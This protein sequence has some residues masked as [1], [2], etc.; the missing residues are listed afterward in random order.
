[1]TPSKP[2]L[3]VALALGACVPSA[4]T[5]P[6][7]VAVVVVDTTR[8]TELGCYGGQVDLTPNLD[9]LAARGTRF[10]NAISNANWTLPSTA[11]LMSGWV[12]E[13]HG[14]V[15]RDHTIDVDAPCLPELFGDAGYGTVA[16]SQMAYVSPEFGFERGFDAFHYEGIGSGIAAE[17]TDERA[18]GW[19]EAAS[20]ERYFAYLHF[21]RPHSPYTPRRNVLARLG[22]VRSKLET[23][24]DAELASADILGVR[25]IPEAAARRARL[26]YRANLAT[27]DEDLGPI[28]ERLERDEALVVLTSDHGEALGEYGGWG[29][30]LWTHADN[31]HIPLI[32]AGPGVSRGVV[33]S[34]AAT[35]DLLPTLAEWCGLDPE[36]GESASGTSLAACLR[37]GSPLAERTMTSLG[38]VHADRATEVAASRGTFKLRLYPDESVR[39]FD[40]SVDSAEA[41][42]VATSHPDL[43][44]DLAEQARRS[45]A[46]AAEH[47]ARAVEAKQRS[48]QVEADLRALGYVGDG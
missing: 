7:R 26:L 17:G 1:M 19:L 30:G 44:A 24:T 18:L 15:G 36:S 22:P 11:S 33:P 32:F 34:L 23:W 21:R 28:L 35:V 5:F 13:R 37:E 46:L 27:Q 45:A 31:L 9:A 41:N 6:E 8:A 29:H 4:P 40:L 39:L 16:F 42:D 48:E 14:L 3:P 43:A 25:E 47:A 2:L 38:K 12:P 10:E 20:G